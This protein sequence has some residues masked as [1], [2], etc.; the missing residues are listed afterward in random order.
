MA[1]TSTLEKHLRNQYLPIFQKMMGMSMAKAKRTFKDLFTKVTE[2][3]G[4]EDTM[5]LPPD[6]GDMLLE[7]ESTDKKVETVLAQKRAEGVRDQNIRWWWNMHDLERRMMSKVDEVFIYALFLRFTKEEGLSAAEANERIRKVRPM[8]GDPADSRYGRGND[9][10]LP[11][12]LRQRVNTYMTRRAQQDPEGLK[13]DA[14]ACSSFNAF[15]RKEIK[16]GNV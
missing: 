9:R 16:V 11:D 4:N 7:K 5:N 3:A 10:P 6:L 12:E 1:K 2:E 13:R 8:F 15:I 14:E